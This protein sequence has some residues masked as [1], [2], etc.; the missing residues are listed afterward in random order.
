MRRFGAFLCCLTVQCSTQAAE[1]FLSERNTEAPF[2]Y[3]QG[4]TRDWPFLEQAL[5]DGSRISFVAKRDDKVMAQ[6][7]RLVFSGLTIRLNPQE[8]LEIISQPD[9]PPVEFTLEVSLHLPDGQVESQH[10]SVRPAPARRPISYLAD[11]GDDLIRIFMD[12]RD[13]HWRPITKSGFD[14]YFRRCQAHGVDRLI[15]W[16]S[17]FPSGQ[18]HA[19]SLA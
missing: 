18:P 7:E 8:N 6:G 17:P 15:L 16:Q 1:A 10:L 5:P 2:C 12:T 11:F 14:Q 3:L 13:G 4:G 9:M 19:K